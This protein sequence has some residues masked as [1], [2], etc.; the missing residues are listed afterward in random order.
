MEEKGIDEK[1]TVNFVKSGNGV[2]LF[3]KC[4]IHP[5]GKYIIRKQ[6]NLFKISISINNLLYNIL[7]KKE[8]R[9]EKR[10]EKKPW[11]FWGMVVILCN[12]LFIFFFFCPFHLPQMTSFPEE[13]YVFQNILSVSEKRLLLLLFPLN[14]SKGNLVIS[15]QL[16]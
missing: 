8:R 2:I 9:K 7:L 14:N 4:I 16:L 6:I 15:Y 10:K 12:S 13:N 3:P 5:I 1:N 11:K